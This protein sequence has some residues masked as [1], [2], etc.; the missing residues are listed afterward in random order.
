ML[1][2]IKRNRKNL[3]PFLLLETINGLPDLDLRFAT[4]NNHIYLSVN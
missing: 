1:I 3:L 4:L 2:N